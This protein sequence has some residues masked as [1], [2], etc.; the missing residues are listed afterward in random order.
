[1][2][3]TEVKESRAVGPAPAVSVPDG[4]LSVNLTSY[5]RHL[6]AGN[7][8][9][10]TIQTYTEAVRQL[11]R[12][13]H[14]S[15]MPTDAARIRREHIEAFIESLLARRH[16]NGEP[17]KPA[18][19]HN[20]YR[21]CRAFFSWL[22]EEGEIRTSPMAKM[23]P[24]RLPEQPVPILRE[25]ELTALLR[26]VEAGKGFDQRRDAAILRTFVSTGARLAE[27]AGL[28]Y[29]PHDETTND[30]DLDQG[31]IR[32]LGKGGRQRIVGLD[33]KS[34]KA[35]DRYLRVRPKHPHAR[36][37]WLWL[38]RK[39]RFGESGIGHMVA[40]RG[41]EAGLPGVH[42]HQLRHSVAHHLLAD[43]MQETDAMRLLGW[44]S[45]DMLVRY[46]A[47]TGTER[48]LAAQRRHAIGERV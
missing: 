1:M 47:S 38:G 21:G 19:A 16:A 42:P 12:F 34:I 31:L 26:T 20:R 10:R 44:R 14:E 2:S 25:A 7:T 17:F 48:A 4:D 29:T 6:R 8:S 3:R 41:R 22:V 43:G 23:K 40:D 11:G 24:P 32:V 15:G 28:R 9:P 45:R 30:V 13:L 27:V 46:A 33:S 36:L 37:P 35:I 18:T 5:A 39:G